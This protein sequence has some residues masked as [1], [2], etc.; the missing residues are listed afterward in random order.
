MH[1]MKEEESIG[2]LHEKTIERQLTCAAS[3]LSDVFLGVSLIVLLAPKCCLHGLSS[4]CTGIER[5]ASLAE[6]DVK[7]KGGKNGRSPFAQLSTCT[8]TYQL[9]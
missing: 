2:E 5:A 8:T 9:L 4:L 6:G 1:K 3:T 7:N